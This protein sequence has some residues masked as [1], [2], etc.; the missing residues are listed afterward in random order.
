MERL[1]FN[2][3]PD[4]SRTAKKKAHLLL[5]LVLDACPHYKSRV[6]CKTVMNLIVMMSA[7]N[8]PY[9]VQ[10]S[11]AYIASNRCSCCPIRYVLHLNEM[12]SVS[13][14]CAPHRLQQAG[15]FVCIT[16]GMKPSIRAWQ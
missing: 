12:A 13:Q 15:V 9:L 3:G 1:L 8:R 5:T 14:G 7:P 16:F 2:T 11:M 6:P 4:Y 10:H